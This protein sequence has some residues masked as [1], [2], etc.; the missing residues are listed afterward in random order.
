MTRAILIPV[1]L[2]IVALFLFGIIQYFSNRHKEIQWE[3][4]KKILEKALYAKNLE[5]KELENWI[6]SLEW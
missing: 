5:V 3:E 2:L 6:K 4:D 1:V